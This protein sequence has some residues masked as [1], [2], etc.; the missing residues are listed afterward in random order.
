MILT[1]TVLILTEQQY[2][3]GLSIESIGTVERPYNKRPRDWQNCS[4]YRGL[5]YI[6]VCCIEVPLYLPGEENII[7]VI[8]DNIL[9]FFTYH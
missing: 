6:E 7:R 5:R 3:A 9:L 8:S 4:L 2:D 1:A